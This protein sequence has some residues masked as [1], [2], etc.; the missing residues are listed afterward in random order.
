M[1]DLWTIGHGT[2]PIGEFIAILQAHDIQVLAD[3]RRFPAS[4]KN[5]QFAQEPFRRALEAAGIQYVHLPDLGG[6]RKG[7]Y[8]AYM[9]T[10]EWL[11]GFAMLEALAGAAR[12]AVCCAETVP[13][14]C[15]RRFVAAHAVDQG[16]SA[17]H[18]LDAR[19]TL[20]ARP[21]EQARLHVTED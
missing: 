1:S 3:I 20:P 2:R 7:G 8:E 12:V 16:W 19:R 14:R 15:H 5:P 4:R 21:P 11:A 17:L 9:Q 6:F 18:I 10:P 13:W